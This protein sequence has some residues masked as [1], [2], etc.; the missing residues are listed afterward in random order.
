M[1]VESLNFGVLD[2]FNDIN[3]CQLLLLL[4]ML[5]SSVLEPDLEIKE[6]F[7]QLNAILSRRIKISA[8]LCT[9][10]NLFSHPLLR[11]CSRILFSNRRDADE[12]PSAGEDDN[13]I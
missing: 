5:R 1:R 2:K 11:Y 8:L 7:D 4:A 10:P 9:F 12:V 13:S 6:L 3:L